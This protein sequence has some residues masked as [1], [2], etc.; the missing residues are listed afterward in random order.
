MK[1]NFKIGQIIKSVEMP[2]LTYIV[3]KIYS[4]GAMEIEDNEGD[5]YTIEPTELKN[6]K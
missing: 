5:K 6:Y 2:M 1:N 4:D 3:K